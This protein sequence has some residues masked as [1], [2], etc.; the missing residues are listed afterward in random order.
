[1]F[2]TV[3]SVGI[4]EI[5]FARKKY[6][7]VYVPGAAHIRHAVAVDE[8]RL[9]FKAALFRQDDDKIIES[10]KAK[11]I[12]EVW[13]PGNHGDIGGGW[14]TKSEA[15]VQLSDVALEW[16]LEEIEQLP[17]PPAEKLAFNHR[18]TEFMDNMKVKRST[19]IETTPCHDALKFRKGWAWPQV[20]F[21]WIL[22]KFSAP[23]FLLQNGLTVLDSQK[24]FRFS[25]GSNLRRDNGFLLI[26]RPMQDPPATFRQAQC[27]TRALSTASTP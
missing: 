5:P 9:K 6:L 11:D 13:F 8:R 2:D 3:N 1:M 19:A 7:P 24:S 17:E 27:F 12:K 14:S 25:R 18:H 20:I 16:M 23:P 10:S 26:G 4:F 22:G 15:D 21:W